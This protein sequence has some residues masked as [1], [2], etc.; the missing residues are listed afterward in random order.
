[1]ARNV[2]IMIAQRLSPWGSATV[3]LS[4]ATLALSVAVMLL[5]IAVTGGFQR[6]I[7]AKLAG[8][9]A[10]VTLTPLGGYD[11]D[12]PRPLKLTP[13]LQDAIAQAFGSQARAATR[14]SHALILKTP[15]DF[16]GVIATAHGNGHDWAFE[17]SNLAAGTLPDTTGRQILLSVPQARALRLE[18]GDKVDAYFITP[19][20]LRQ[21]RLQVSGLYQ[22]NLGEYDK[23]VAIVASRLLEPMMGR[24]PGQ[25][26]VIEINGLSDTPDTAIETGARQLQA[27]LNRQ[28]MTGIIPQPVAVQTL[29]QAQP[30]YFNWLDLLDTNVAVVLILMGCVS[31]FTLI[32]CCFILILQ[33]VRLIGQL[34]ALGMT[35]RALRLIFIWLGLK[36]MGWGIALGTLLA[37]ALA[38]LQAATRALPLDPASYYISYV[39]VY[40]AWWQVAAVALGALALAALLL[41]IPATVIGHISPATTMRFE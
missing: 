30:A 8:F 15:D 29:R 24:E 23:V 36:V 26:A 22:S 2:S 20:G 41:L 11:G 35:T 4:V 40:L 13:E 3:R 21:R 31:G 16:L 27:W 12:A 1:M 18:P 19:D 39:P 28:Y 9:E 10:A 33:R 6:Q 25:G 34:K 7:R 32:A 37:I 38:W 17:R 5:S 14:S